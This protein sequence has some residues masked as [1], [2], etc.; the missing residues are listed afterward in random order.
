MLIKSINPEVSCEYSSIRKII[1][2]GHGEKLYQ[3][4][5]GYFQECRSKDGKI[6]EVYDGKPV[7]ITLGTEPKQA[8]K[9][10]L[11][12]KDNY[13][14]KYHGDYSWES[15]LILYI[16]ESEI[17]VSPAG[18]YLAFENRGEAN[19][20]KAVRLHFTHGATMRRL[21]LERVPEAGKDFTPPEGCK[22]SK[23]YSRDPQHPNYDVIYPRPWADQ[24]GPAE[25]VK[26][27]LEN[28]T[29]FD[30]LAQCDGYSRT[31]KTPERLQREKLAKMMNEA[32]LFRG[33]VSHYDIEEMLKIFDISVKEV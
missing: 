9:E 2:Y 11:S 6:S 22:W 25:V 16:H 32:G 24:P 30:F 12:R 14:L 15:G 19:Y 20:K 29:V 18:E 27:W 8:R 4:G 13:F 26:R 21:K 3:A 10:N 31:E 28:E 5:N 33:N 7:A 17:S 23:D 1:I